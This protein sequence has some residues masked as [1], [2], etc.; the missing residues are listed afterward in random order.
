[1]MKPGSIIVDLAAE[2]GGNCALTKPHEINNVNGVKIIGYADLPSRLAGQ[3][4]ALYANN[5][6]KFL[7]QILVKEGK[8]TTNLTDEI[9]RGA[10]VTDKGELL[11]PNPN[12]P[13]LDAGKAQKPKEVAKKKEEVVTDLFKP[14]LNT[15]LSMA[16]T[17]ASIVGVGVLCPD[18]AFMTM[19]STFS[20]AL[21]AGY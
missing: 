11:W 17:L 13:Q 3:S 19:F 5:I 2:A 8:T 21:I 14:T 4:S 9:A 1:M 7:Q 6:S 12:P 20:L 18:P 15:A 16:A 10:V